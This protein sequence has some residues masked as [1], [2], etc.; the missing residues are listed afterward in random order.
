MELITCAHRMLCH[1]LLRAPSEC[2]WLDQVTLLHAC[3]VCN[4]F[5]PNHLFTLYLSFELC[6]P[7]REGGAHMDCSYL[8]VVYLAHS[9]LI[10][11]PLVDTDH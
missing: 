6:A 2:A 8:S 7:P 4:S 9:R 5:H 11:Q 10:V 3:M 1:L